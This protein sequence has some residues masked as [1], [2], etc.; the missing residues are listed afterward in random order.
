[1][2]DMSLVDLAGISQLLIIAK[3]AQIFDLEIEGAKE[4]G[5]V[6]NV[7]TALKTNQML[8]KMDGVDADRAFLLNAESALIFYRTKNYD[9]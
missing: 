7:Q 3:Q 8:S 9:V 4:N 1:M 6:K 2:T 5:S